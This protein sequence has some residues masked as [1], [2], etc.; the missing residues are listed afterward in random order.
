MTNLTAVAARTARRIMANQELTH[1][2]MIL[3][4]V[5]FHLKQSG[6]R[7]EFPDDVM[8]SLLVYGTLTQVLMGL[9]SLGWTHG[10]EE[11]VMGGLYCSGTSVTVEG[12]QRLQIMQTTFER[13]TVWIARPEPV[14]PAPEVAPETQAPVL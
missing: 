3:S 8:N 14:A 12:P 1:E 11:P 13:V 2:G 10:E 5:Q 9:T 7:S 4:T 6:I